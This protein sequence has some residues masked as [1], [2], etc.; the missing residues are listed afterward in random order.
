MG[1]G[2]ALREPSVAAC[3]DQLPRFSP[4]RKWSTLP[5][6]ECR[7][8]RHLSSKNPGRKASLRRLT[9]AARRV[10]ISG[11]TG[12]PDHQ[13]IQNVASFS[14]A[15]DPN[16]IGRARHV[17]LPRTIR[18]IGARFRKNRHSAGLH[19]RSPVRDATRC[20]RDNHQ[21]LSSLADSNR[22]PLE[23]DALFQTNATI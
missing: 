8:M 6:I 3:D 13:N 11:Q 4:P 20:C 7:T 14:L 23:S 16:T 17:G 9:Q 2:F 19:F 10:S 21:R 18:R 1:R 15:G 12:S 22:I 5:S